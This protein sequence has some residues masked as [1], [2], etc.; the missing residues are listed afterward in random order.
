MSNK[1]LQ[2]YLSMS[3]VIGFLVDLILILIINTQNKEIYNYLT[4]GICS[5]IPY[6]TFVISINIKLYNKIDLKKSI[7]LGIIYLIISF[8]AG[9]L[10]EFLIIDKL[11]N[12][13][14]VNII[15][16]VNAFY[17][18]GIGTLVSVNFS[19]DYFRKMV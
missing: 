19:Y 11:L 4:V 5:I 13:D 10:I 7:L 3:V 2:S 9:F 12:K 8:V 17:Q 14:I 16:I 15:R 1:K 18:A 6:I